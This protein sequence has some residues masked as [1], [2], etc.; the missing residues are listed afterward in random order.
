MGLALLGWLDPGEADRL[1]DGA[2]DVLEESQSE[3]GAWP[4]SRVISQTGGKL[5]HIASYDV[6]R[7]LAILLQGRLDGSMHRH[8]E[9]ILNLID[10]TIE[11]AR[12]TYVGAGSRSHNLRGWGNDRTRYADT[13]ESWATSVVL[14]LLCRRREILLTLRE[15]AAPEKGKDC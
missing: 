6:A 13:V 11:L 14:M 12:G 15:S 9:R 5:L 4:T 1:L 3:D 7:A 2:L 8:S 10:K